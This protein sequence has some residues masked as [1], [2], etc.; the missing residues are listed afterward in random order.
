MTIGKEG[1]R[2]TAVGKI[3]LGENKIIEVYCLHF[4][5]RMYISMRLFFQIFPNCSCSSSIWSIVSCLNKSVSKISISYC[6]SKAHVFIVCKLFQ[7][8]WICWCKNVVRNLWSNESPNWDKLSVL[9][10][11]AWVDR[12]RTFSISQFYLY[13]PVELRKGWCWCCLLCLGLCLVRRRITRKAIISSQVSFR[14]VKY[15]FKTHF[16]LFY[17]SVI[18][19]W[20]FFLHSIIQ[21]W[22]CTIPRS[23]RL[24]HM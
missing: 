3:A 8:A 10:H 21:K 15:V 11:E 9:G 4:E 17:N 22:I 5:K 18:Y 24:N 14:L 19:K 23:Q 2:G 12:R 13:P 7:F 16:S 6:S 20:F 1:R